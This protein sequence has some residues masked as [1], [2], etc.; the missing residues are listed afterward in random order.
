MRERERERERER[1]RVG[2]KYL[3]APK[4]FDLYLTQQRLIAE[5]AE[6][7]FADE[8][9]LLESTS[10]PVLSSLPSVRI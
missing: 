10:P 1:V 4:S 2:R 8:L 3:T 5:T 6:K 7:I 9:T